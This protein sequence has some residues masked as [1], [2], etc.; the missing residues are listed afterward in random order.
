MIFSMSYKPIRK[1][2][3]LMLLKWYFYKYGYCTLFIVYILINVASIFP[4]LY[5]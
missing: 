5:R 4:F 2:S 1:E 3:L